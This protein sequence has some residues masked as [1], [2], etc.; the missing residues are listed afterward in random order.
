ML[1]NIIILPIDLTLF[2]YA[3]I[4]K[5]TLTVH[6]ATLYLS[7]VQRRGHVLFDK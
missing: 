2:P 6:K 1:Q 4:K 7:G 3:H 5:D